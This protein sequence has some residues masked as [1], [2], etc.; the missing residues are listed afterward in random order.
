MVNPTLS[1]RDQLHLIVMTEAQEEKNQKVTNLQQSGS[2]MSVW[3]CSAIGW[4]VYMY[5][6]S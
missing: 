6:P 4:I 1:H 5:Q 2:T 3:F